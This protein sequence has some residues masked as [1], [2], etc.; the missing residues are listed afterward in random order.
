[1]NA[2]ILII[3]QVFIG[4]KQLSNLFS[5]QGSKVTISLWNSGE[6]MGMRLKRRT[7]RDPASVGGLH[8]RRKRLT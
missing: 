6:I 7:G 2:A 3:A 5:A 1:M 8:V 4:P